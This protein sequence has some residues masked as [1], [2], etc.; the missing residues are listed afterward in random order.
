[1]ERASRSRA[2]RELRTLLRAGATSGLSDAELL[3]RF[4]SGSGKPAESAFEALVSRHGPM[5][6]DVCDKVLGNAHDVQ[7]ALQ[8]TF[9]ILAVK[10]GSI[11]RQASIASWL[12]GVA[13]RV[14]LHA[15]SEA[16]RRR[17]GERRL[18]ASA[19][20]EVAWTP[21]EDREHVD[22]LHQEI[23]R[24]PRNYREPVVAC[25]LEGLTLEMAARQI[26]LSDRH[27]GRAADASTRTAQVAI[28]PPWHHRPGGSPD[29]WPVR[30]VDHCGVAGHPGPYHGQ[31]RHPVRIER[32]DHARRHR[33]NQGRAHE[34]G[35][36]QA[37][38]Q[39]RWS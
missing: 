29:R 22:I 19:N 34:D 26:A 12:H 23:E 30:R 21:P 7:D 32:D 31:D 36:D 18:A 2:V 24:L 13:L 25:Y 6:L 4:V 8:S 9:L 17:A 28:E 1:M 16:A 37:G 14:A 3:A 10:A 27:P 38:T 15:R 35:P 11:R 5:V 20:S 39:P 33:V